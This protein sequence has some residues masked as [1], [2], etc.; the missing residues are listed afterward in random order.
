[1]HLSIYKNV[2]IEENIMKKKDLKEL[3]KVLNSFSPAVERQAMINFGV[4]K[5]KY[6]TIDSVLGDNIDEFR[7]NGDEVTRKAK[8]VLCIIRE[9]GYPK[10]GQ[11]TPK[12][13]AVLY[14]VAFPSW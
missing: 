10:E 11:L 7:K 1:M 12:E 6:D 5:G 8:K 14:E 2:A 4:V 9:K 3:K 13:E